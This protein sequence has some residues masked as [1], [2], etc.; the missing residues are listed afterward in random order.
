MWF[1]H[2]WNSVEDQ[3]NNKIKTKHHHNGSNTLFKKVFRQKT[4]IE[5]NSSDL[6]LDNKLDIRQDRFDP[7][8]HIIFWPWLMILHTTTAKVVEHPKTLS[9]LWKYYM[10]GIGRNKTSNFFHTTRM[11]QQRQ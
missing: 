2:V 7:K 3:Q 8:N 10:F 5:T 4:S 11:Q 1:L 9:I 6:L